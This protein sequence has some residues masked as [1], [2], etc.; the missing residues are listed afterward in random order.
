MSSPDSEE[1]KKFLYGRGH[2][3]Q[4][5][6]RRRIRQEH[7]TPILSLPKQIGLKLNQEVTIEKV[8]SNPLTW[9]IRIKPVE[10]RVECA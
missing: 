9:E 5:P 10:K 1:Q 8:D 6:I 4:K 2:K 3:K 7:G